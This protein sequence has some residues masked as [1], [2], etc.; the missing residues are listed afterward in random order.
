MSESETEQQLARAFA[1]SEPLRR[2]ARLLFAADPCKE[3]VQVVNYFNR[4][5]HRRHIPRQLSAENPSWF[6]DPTIA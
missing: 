5:R 6:V 1:P 4:F 3:L 2:R